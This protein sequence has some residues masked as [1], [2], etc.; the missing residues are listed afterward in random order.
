MLVPPNAFD[1]PDRILR[2]EFAEA[3]TDM[4]EVL[5]SGWVIAIGDASQP[6]RTGYAYVMC[7]DE[8]S[9]TLNLAFLN[10]DPPPS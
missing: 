8:E 9:N 2:M 7:A 6:T 1:A 5:V 3:I 4:P 10:W